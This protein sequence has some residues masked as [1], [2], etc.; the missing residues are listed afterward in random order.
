M[1]RAPA[2]ILRTNDNVRPV[3]RSAGWQPDVS[4]GCQPADPRWTWR[5]DHG[6]VLPIANRRYSRLPTGATYANDTNGDRIDDQLLAR[7]EQAFASAAAAFTP[8]EV[9]ASQANLAQI[10]EV[11]LVFTQ[12]ITQA[13]LDDYLR[14]G[15]QI[16]YVYKAVSY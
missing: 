14:T 2:W 4:Q 15:G 11:E 9:A 7:A 6:Y 1:I 3:G 5:G 12:Q 10:I 8:E 13:Q 16:D